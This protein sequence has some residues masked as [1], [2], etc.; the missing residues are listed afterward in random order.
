MIG[1]IA[2]VNNR[3]GYCAVECEI[4][5]YS[6]FELRGRYDIAIGDVLRGNLR[7]EGCE[8]ITNLTQQE[9]ISV[10]FEG[11]G[12]EKRQA[13]KMCVA[14]ITLKNSRDG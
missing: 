7:S 3:S 5:E 8:T 4:G 14:E 12:L 10:C 9:K 13:L 1:Q 6:V 11:R 2:F